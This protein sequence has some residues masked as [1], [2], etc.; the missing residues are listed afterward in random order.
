MAAFARSPRV[1]E[2]GVEQ[3]NDIREMDR[4][5]S[6]A[7]RPQREVRDSGTGEPAALAHSPGSQ[8]SAPRAQHV[9]VDQEHARVRRLAQVRGA[10]GDGV[11]HRLHV[12]RRARDD[13]QD[14][15]DRRL[16]LER[17]LQLAGA[18]VDLALEPRVRLAQLPVIRLNWSA[19]ASS[20]SPVRTSI[21]WS[22]SPS[23]MRCAPSSQRAD[24]P[25]H[26][27]RERQRAQRRDHQAR[28]QQQRRCAG[29]TR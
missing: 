15:A 21:F 25:H 8:S 18:L 4:R 23:P 14:L 2:L 11:E 9:A 27:A 1:R 17:V 29:S 20:S 19:S 16:L 22:R 28:E 13:A 12:G 3:R 6:S 26:A 5:R 7:A 24:R 10:L